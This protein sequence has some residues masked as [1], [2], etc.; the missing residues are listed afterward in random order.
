MLVYATKWVPPGGRAAVYNKVIRTCTCSGGTPP[1]LV[2]GLLYNKLIRTRPCSGGTPPGGRAAVYNKL[3]R[4]RTCSGGTPPGGRAAVYNKVIHTR[5]CSGG[6]DGSRCETIRH[7]GTSLMH[8]S[9][10]QGSH[11]VDISSPLCC[12]RR[13]QSRLLLNQLKKCS[14]YCSSRRN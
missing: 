5:T 3:I 12:S 10:S 7:E 14:I 9:S 13:H 6:C 4:T 11:W 2:A 8:L 1:P